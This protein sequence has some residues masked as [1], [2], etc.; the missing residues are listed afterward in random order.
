MIGDASLRY[1]RSAPWL[2]VRVVDAAGKDVP[3]GVVGALVHVDLANRSSSIAI[4]TEDLG[5]LT[6]DGLVLIGRERGA[7]LRGCSLDAEALRAR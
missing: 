6:D 5:A 1:K 3:D 2:R 4:S 7:A